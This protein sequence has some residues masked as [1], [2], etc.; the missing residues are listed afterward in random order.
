MSK[1]TWRQRHEDILKKGDMK[2]VRRSWTYRDITKKIQM[3]FVSEGCCIGH[4]KESIELFLECCRMVGYAT[5]SEGGKSVSIRSTVIDAEYLLSNLFG[6][7]TSIRGFDELF[8]GGGLML[9]EEL[10][11]ADPHTPPGRTVLVIGRYGT[12]TS[13]LSMQLAIEVAQKGGLA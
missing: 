2:G 5:A 1:P 6:I 9:T 13:H 4:K 11:L 3:A 12:G 8:G 7:P 10:H